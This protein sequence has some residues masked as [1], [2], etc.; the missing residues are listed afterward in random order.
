[1]LYQKLQTLTILLLAAG[2]TPGV[3]VAQ[4]ATDYLPQYGGSDWTYTTE[5]SEIM[6]EFEEDFPE[7][8]SQR[9]SVKSID[10]EDTLTVYRM[11]SMPLDDFGFDDF[12]GDFDDEVEAAEYGWMV[13]EDMVSPL[14]EIPDEFDEE[15]PAR[16]SANSANA[17]LTGTAMITQQFDEEDLEFL[18]L[19]RFNTQ[20]G[21]EWDLINVDELIEIPEEARE[22]PEFPDFIESIEINF[23]LKGSRH[24]Q[25]DVEL[26]GD[27]HTA[28]VFGTTMSLGITLNM[29]DEFDLPDVEAD[30]FDEYSYTTRW[31]E[32]YGNVN[33][34]AES[35]TI[36]VEELMEL[37]EILEGGGETEAAKLAD[38]AIGIAEEDEFTELIIPAMNTQ[39]SDYQEGDRDVSSEIVEADEMPDSPELKQNY[40]NPFN[41]T[42]TISYELPENGQVELNVYDVSGRHITTLV[43]QN[44]QA[45]AHQVTWDASNMS[46][47]VYIYQLR[48]DNTVISN[49]MTLV[50]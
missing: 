25:E 29:D 24:D 47:G 23:H 4:D 10:V 46:S 2:I 26:D 27:T 18:P 48:Y 39:M 21:D 45:G 14:I 31:V 5:F 13:Y 16:L 44:Q 32:S 41:P 38:V 17:N 1:M 34:S 36:D 30:I 7:S 15:L 8:I 37:I 11:E 50:K 49:E 22:D 42:T 28:E 9:D 12:N 40:P 43:D 20:P 19:F 3:A 35:H 6:E 33:S